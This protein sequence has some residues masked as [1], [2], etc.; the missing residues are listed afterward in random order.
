[1]K[2]QYRTEIANLEASHPAWVR[3]LKQDAPPVEVVATLSHPAWVRGLKL[4]CTKEKDQRQ[5]SHPAWVRGLKRYLPSRAMPQTV[6]APRVGAWI[7]TI[8]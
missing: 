2:R 8:D 4:Y 1:M 6:V 7:E 3:G 5:L